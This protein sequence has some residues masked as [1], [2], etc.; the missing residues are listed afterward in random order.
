MPAQKP[1]VL[2]FDIDGTLIR[3][4]AG[5]VALDRV[6]AARYGRT[7]VLNFSFAGMTDQVIL[8]RGL[9]AAVGPESGEGAG[10]RPPGPRIWP[11]K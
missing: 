7:D 6:F 4:G 3:T 1:T 5:R 8:R 9:E 2:L 10:A 11:S